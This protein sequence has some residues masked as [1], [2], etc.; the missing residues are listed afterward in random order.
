MLAVDDKY[1]VV[2]ELYRQSS[3]ATT[4]FCFLI[5]LVKHISLFF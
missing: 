3:L 2:I 5:I 4:I 1:Y